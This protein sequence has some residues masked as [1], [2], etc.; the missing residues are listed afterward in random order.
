MRSLKRAV[1]SSGADIVVPGDDR[2]L[3][4]LHRLHANG[5]AH[6]KSVVQRSLGSPLFYDAVRSRLGFSAASRAC[7]LRVPEDTSLETEADLR[8]WCAR[9][10]PP[11][12]F[13]SD[14]AWSGRGVRI[15]STESDA[16]SA[17]RDLRKGVPLDRVFKRAMIDGDLFWAADWLQQRRPPS[18]SA[19]AFIPG[20]PGNLAVF[21]TD[22][23]VEAFSAVVSEACFD[24]TG[25]SVLI[26]TI[27]VPGLREGI[28]RLASH[29][30]L[31]GF[32]GVDFILDDRDG[33]PSLIE[34]NARATP[35]ANLRLGADHDLV[36]AATQAWSGH[37]ACLP[38]SQPTDRLIAHFPALLALECGRPAPARV[39]RGHSIRGAGASARDAGIFLA[40]ATPACA[41]ALPSPRRGQAGP[42][43]AAASA[44]PAL[45]A[46]RGVARVQRLQNRS[47]RSLTPARAPPPFTHAAAFPPA[48]PCVPMRHPAPHSHGNRSSRKAPYASASH[49]PGSACRHR[50]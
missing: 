5:T 4:H 3:A 46:G 28:A 1:A 42:A 44:V 45:E 15:I 7:G 23:R 26:R 30:G 11:W 24:A 19:Q 34:L 18:V 36:G 31:S 16:E 10:P 25:P 33:Q 35:L 6:E 49:P 39:L 20:R 14:G 12:V 17:F 21:C 47:G 41:L 2:A 22:G 29:L 50:A 38:P 27:D 32:H 37:P 9:V 43:R 40:R 13:K 8:R 48:S